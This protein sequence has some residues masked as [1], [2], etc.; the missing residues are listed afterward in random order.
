MHLETL[1][2][3]EVLHNPSPLTLI[4][5]YIAF[6]E[7]VEGLRGDILSLALGPFEVSQILVVT[8]N[9]KELLKQLAAMRIMR[10]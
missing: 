6:F 10:G 2:K 9:D 5:T 4:T 3:T 1:W 7:H 8:A